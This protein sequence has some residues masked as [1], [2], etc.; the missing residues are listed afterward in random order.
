MT[1]KHTSTMTSH[2]NKGFR[3]PSA[4]EYSTSQDR[5][6]PGEILILKFVFLSHCFLLSPV[7]EFCGLLIKSGISYIIYIPV[8]ITGASAT[9]YCICIK[10][11]LYTMTYLSFPLH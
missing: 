1:V 8:Y 3:I 2:S 6:I 4:N 5:V 9:I 10:Y 7:M 11:S